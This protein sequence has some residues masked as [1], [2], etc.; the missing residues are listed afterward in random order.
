MKRG[1]NDWFARFA[2]WLQQAFPA[3]TVSSKNGCVPATTTEYASMC[4]VRALVWQPVQEACAC[5]VQQLSELG[6]VSAHPC[7][8]HAEWLLPPLLPPCRRGSWTQP[9]LT[10]SF[11]ST[12]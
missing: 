1:V 8:L 7:S 5:V 3:A 6:S 10:W 4:L 2:A 9:L 11:W 12:A